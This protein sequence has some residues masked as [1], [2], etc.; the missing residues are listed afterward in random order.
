[1][2][3]AEGFRRLS[4]V[5]IV[6]SGLVYFYLELDAR[7]EP[8]LAMLRSAIL[9]IGLWLTLRI[10]MWIVN[11]FRAPPATQSDIAITASRPSDRAPA[12]QPD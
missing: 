11:G 5:L 12:P 2:N 10:V 4:S 9:V 3:F 8:Q 6:G 1:M 7:T